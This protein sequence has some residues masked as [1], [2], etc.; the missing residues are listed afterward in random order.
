LIVLGIDHKRE[1]SRRR[2]HR[3]AGSI[4]EQRAAESALRETLV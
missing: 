3:A 4:R 2:L 1:H